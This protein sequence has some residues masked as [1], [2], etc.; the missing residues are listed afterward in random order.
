VISKDWIWFQKDSSPTM[1]WYPLSNP[2]FDDFYNIFDSPYLRL[3]NQLFKQRI[4]ND[5]SKSQNPTEL[6][7][8]QTKS[9]NNKEIHLKERS[10]PNPPKSMQA[11]SFR[12]SIYRGNN[13]I[14]HIY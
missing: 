11:Y 8:E 12:T 3:L 9:G 13:G 1:G 7:E 4:S 14:E 10:K 5:T 2:Q 6:K